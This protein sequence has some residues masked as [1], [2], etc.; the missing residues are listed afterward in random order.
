[1]RKLTI[2]LH[3]MELPE[4]IHGALTLNKGNVESYSIFINNKQKETEQAVS[5]IHEMLH[6]YRRDFDSKK[7]VQQIEAETHEMT[8]RI[9]EGLANEGLL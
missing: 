9:S 2:S 1:M 5:F 8:R 4:N 7:D 3:E 6:I